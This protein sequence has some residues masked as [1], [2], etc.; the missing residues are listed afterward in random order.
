[1]QSILLVC[2]FFI[3]VTIAQ[4]STPPVTNHSTAAPSSNVSE[5]PTVNLTSTPQ[6]QGTTQQQE[7]PATSPAPSS[8]GATVID[9]T[10]DDDDSS[11]GTSS[12]SKKTI[13]VAGICGI[14]VFIVGVVVYFVYDASKQKTENV[15]KL[16][17]EYMKGVRTGGIEMH[18]MEMHAQ[19]PRTPQTTHGFY[20][21]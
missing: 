21:L 15:R 12:S 17:Q 3:V 5:L 4:S 13:M 20:P 7:V 16:L 9:P 19:P 11:P 1:M 18:G 10:S 14:A 2:C 6:P 8:Y